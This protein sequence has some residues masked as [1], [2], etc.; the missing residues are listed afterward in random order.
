MVGIE[1]G[2]IWLK[3]N[4]VYLVNRF[5]FVYWSIQQTFVL[6][7]VHS[8]WDTPTLSLSLSYISASIKLNIN[9][10]YGNILI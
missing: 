3:I 8:S 2:W 7:K 1:N 10:D 9:I 5:M 6:W 4:V